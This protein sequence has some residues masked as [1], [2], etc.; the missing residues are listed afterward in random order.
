[1]PSANK[2]NYGLLTDI[3]R[4]PHPVFAN[5]RIQVILSQGEYAWMKTWPGLHAAPISSQIEW[6]C[7]SD[8]FHLQTDHRSCHFQHNFIGPY[9]EAR[10]VYEQ[11]DAKQRSSANLAWTAS[12]EFR[13][14]GFLLLGDC[15]LL[16]GNGVRK[17]GKAAGADGIW[18]STP[19]ECRP[20]RAGRQSGRTLRVGSRMGA[21]ACGCQA[22][23]NPRTRGWEATAARRVR[24]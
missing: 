9:A 20:W 13:S 17:T 22:G 5:S 12:P 10:L 15:M 3:S 4:P 11:V 2:S 8:N 19:P 7:E 18:P 1:M 6:S 24:R 23:E 16:S 14:Y 21:A